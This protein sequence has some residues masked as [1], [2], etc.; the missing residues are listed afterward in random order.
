[1]G[2]TAHELETA[3]VKS[4]LTVKALLEQD[5]ST[6]VWKLSK[7]TGIT[8]HLDNC[9]RN[10]LEAGETLLLGD[11]PTEFYSFTGFTA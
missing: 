3:G 11:A 7:K 10:I 5:I 4:V 6:G 9:F 8:V 1:M 2:V